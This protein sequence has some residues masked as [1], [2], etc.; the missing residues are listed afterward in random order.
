MTAVNRALV[1]TPVGVAT[2]LPAASVASAGPTYFATIAAKVFTG[3]FG[4][5]NSMPANF[6]P[7]VK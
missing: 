5:V 3:Q 1:T 6:E 2:H 7:G 4:T